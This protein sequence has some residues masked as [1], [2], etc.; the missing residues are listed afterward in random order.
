MFSLCA[1]ASNMLWLFSFKA[2]NCLANSAPLSVCT[3]ST[4][5]PRALNCE[6]TRHKNKLDE[7][8]LR[9][10]YPY[11]MRYREYSSMAVYWYSSVLLY[12]SMNVLDKHSF[13]T[14]FTSIWIHSPGYFIGSYGR[15]F[16]QAGD[17][18]ALGFVGILR[19]SKGLVGFWCSLAL[20]GAA[21]DPEGQG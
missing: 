15:L 19:R 20:L 8:V 3:H 6:A 4:S 2:V 14:Y 18:L 10:R 9:S 21:I 17:G 11:K 12:F 7:Y 16:R 1:V 13:G 5:M